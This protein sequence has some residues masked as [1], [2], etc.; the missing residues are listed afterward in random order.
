M[1]RI[2]SLVALA[3]C[4]CFPAF[5]GTAKVSWLTFCSFSYLLYTFVDSDDEPARNAR[6]RWA[7]DTS[8]NKTARVPLLL[9]AIH[10]ML[11]T[12]ADS[13]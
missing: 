2:P 5:L 9:C 7:F 13:S 10:R 12:L 8:T 6:R 11:A 4:T 1:A 3:S